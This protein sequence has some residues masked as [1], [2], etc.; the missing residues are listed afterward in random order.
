MHL[1]ETYADMNA[2]HAAEKAALSTR[3]LAERASYYALRAERKRQSIVPHVEDFLNYLGTGD[4][5][6][7]LT[8][9]E[10]RAY[11]IRARVPLREILDRASQMQLRITD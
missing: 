3:H 1:P 10:A 9:H 5:R 6:N 8:R 2:R 11:A 7:T 4:R